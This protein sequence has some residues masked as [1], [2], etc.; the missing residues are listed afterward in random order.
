MNRGLLMPPLNAL[1]RVN[2][3]GYAKRCFPLRGVINQPCT[4]AGCLASQP[5][6][7]TDSFSRLPVHATLH[8]DLL[9]AVVSYVDLQGGRV[10]RQSPD[11]G[12]GFNRLEKPRLR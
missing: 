8:I 2:R 7:I 1:V 12:K 10:P 5:G 3:S 4:S 6:A 11:S 9:A